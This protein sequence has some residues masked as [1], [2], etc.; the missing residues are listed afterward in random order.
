VPTRISVCAANL[1]SGGPA[2]RIQNDEGTRLVYTAKGSGSWWI[3][4]KNGRVLLIV[5]EATEVYPD[6]DVDFGGQPNTHPIQL[7]VTTKEVFNLETGELV[8]VIPNEKYRFYWAHNHLHL[9]PVEYMVDEKI[10]EARKADE[11]KPLGESR[12]PYC[13]ECGDGVLKIVLDSIQDHARHLRCR[14]CGFDDVN[15][16]VLVVYEKDGQFPSKHGRFSVIG[17]RNYNDHTDG[18]YKA[19]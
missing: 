17:R 8:A 4:R 15:Q 5:E 18:D 13:P 10:T 16:G 3:G 9:G 6:L 7:R 1:H 14:D 19:T 12:T 2:V 11:V